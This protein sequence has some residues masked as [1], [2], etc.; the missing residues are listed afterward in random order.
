MRAQAALHCSGDAWGIGPGEPR[1]EHEK[2]RGA[3]TS[4]TEEPRLEGDGSR[5][6]RGEPLP[7]TPTQQ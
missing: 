4:A 2:S 7:K 1:L 3:P 5:E 6:G